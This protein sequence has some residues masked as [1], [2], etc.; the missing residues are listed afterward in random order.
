MTAL[1]SLLA[2][3]TFAAQ[4]VAAQGA[5]KAGGASAKQSPGGFSGAIVTYR[6]KHLL[7]PQSS[8]TPRPVATGRLLLSPAATFET[9]L[10]STVP[11]TLLESVRSPVRDPA[12]LKGQRPAASPTGAAPRS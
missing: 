9:K 10:E 12:P 6:S 1:L 5:A 3:I 7:A 2:G 4:G 11:E 8:A